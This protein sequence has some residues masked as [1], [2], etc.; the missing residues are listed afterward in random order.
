MEKEEEKGIS[1][2][3]FLDFWGEKNLPNFEKEEE[4][5]MFLPHFSW[6]LERRGEWGW[7]GHS[8]FVLAF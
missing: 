4:M 5:Y 3:T 7:G 1:F 8:F 2:H 6:V